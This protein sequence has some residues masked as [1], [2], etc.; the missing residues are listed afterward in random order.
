MKV[1]ILA[2]GLGTRLREEN[3]YRPKPMVEIGGRPIIWHIMKIFAG[4]GHTDFIL[5]L[6]Y[7]GDLIRDYFLNYEMHNRDFT[8]ALGQRRVEILNEHAECGWR[9][10]L[11]ETGELTNTGGRIKRVAKYLGSQTFMATY[12]D[13]VA[14]IDLD[15][16]LQ[17]HRLHAKLAT[18]TGVHPSSRFGELSIENGLVRMYR[19]KPQVAEG[20][21]NGGFFIFEAAALELIDGDEDNLETNLLMR[22]TERNELAVYQDQGFWQCMDTY[23]EMKLL[24]ELWTLGTAPWACWREQ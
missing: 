9:V 6:G 4:H 7:K 21:I 22:L 11:A 24:N 18:V 15:R 2:G 17:F 19:E 13:G 10:T 3:E 1:V 20:W 5:C 14:D 16:L 12:G 8:V 23:R